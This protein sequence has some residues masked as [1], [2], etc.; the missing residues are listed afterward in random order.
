MYLQNGDLTFAFNLHWMMGKK[1]LRV[2]P[3]SGR[4]GKTAR[5]GHLE[6]KGAS[7]ASLRC[8]SIGIS[9]SVRKSALPDDFSMAKFS[10]PSLIKWL[11]SH[12][13]NP[14]ET[15]NRQTAWHEALQTSLLIWDPDDDNNQAKIETFCMKV[16][17]WTKTVALLV[18]NGADDRMWHAW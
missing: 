11:I 3:V 18:E 17:E 5:I 16:R 2:N 12:G 15:Y 4:Q 14:N 7:F 10:S 6:P 13:A 8:N 9:V 1:A